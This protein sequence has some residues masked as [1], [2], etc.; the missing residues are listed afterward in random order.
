MKSSKP[1][2]RVIPILGL[3]L[4]GI[5]FLYQWASGTSSSLPVLEYYGY[6]RAVP[7]EDSVQVIS[8]NTGAS[9]SRFFFTSVNEQRV[10]GLLSIPDSAKRPAPIVILIHG[11]GDSKE[12]DYIRFG[13]RYF[14]DN[15][16]AVLR[17]DLYGHGER[18]TR[19]FDF[20]LTGDYRY[21]TRNIIT[22]SVFD[23]RRA[24][25]FIEA[26]ND[27]DAQRIGYF[28]VS[29][30]GIIGTLFCGVEE[31]IK[32]PV[33]VLA[34]GQLNLLYE[35]QGFSS[36]AKDFVSMVEP[37]NFVD[38]IAPRPLLMLNAKNDEVVPPLM[39][40]LLFRKARKPKEI[41]WYDAKH[42]D[43]PV[44]SVYADGVKW[45]KKYL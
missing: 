17:I 40:K 9:V 29:L 28:G 8:N 14:L 16:Y 7:L 11:L 36:E 30:G 45:F 43:V 38:R 12:A 5:F 32:V 13:T 22:Q 33:I 18:K 1:G 41:I 20:D 44:D 35:K 15:G 27:L 25:D 26:Q 21:W 37:L 6:D 31:R 10:T 3:T 23:L 19:I 24:V 4:L 34:G 39:S 42:R 2:R